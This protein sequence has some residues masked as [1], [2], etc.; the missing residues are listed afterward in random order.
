MARIFH[1]AAYGDI[2][3]HCEVLTE[4]AKADASAWEHAYPEL[5]GHEKNGEDL[6]PPPTRVASI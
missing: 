2:V 3:R 1:G 4:L 5:P 6:I